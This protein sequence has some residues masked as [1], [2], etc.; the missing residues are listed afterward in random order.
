M[1]CIENNVSIFE[2]F[3]KIKRRN[4]RRRWRQRR[5]CEL[6]ILY[7]K[8]IIMIKIIDFSAAC[9]RQRGGH[10]DGSQFVHFADKI[11]QN[12]FE[13]KNNNNERK[14]AT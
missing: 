10:G 12:T 3:P 14:T 8:I 4:R 13:Q 6:A 5:H 7:N 9:H 2:D 11:C 1:L